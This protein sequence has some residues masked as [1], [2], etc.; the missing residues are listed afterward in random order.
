[1]DKMSSR[2]MER[3]VIYIKDSKARPARSLYQRNNESLPCF[4]Y[5]HMP[6][7]PHP[8]LSVVASWPAPNYVNPEGRGRVTTIIAGVLSPITFFVIFA[9]I[10]VRF[11]LQRNPGWDDWLMVVALVCSLLPTKIYTHSPLVAIHHCLSHPCT[12]Q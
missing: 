6:G 2:E 10:W 9:R 8:P 3:C 7:G 1:M 5:A 11:Y 12:I 4:I